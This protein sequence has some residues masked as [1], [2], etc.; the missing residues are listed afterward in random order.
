LQLD[1]IDESPL[2]V[3]QVAGLACFSGATDQPLRGAPLKEGLLWYLSA[4]KADVVD[5]SL[6]INGFSFTHSGEELSVSFSPFTLVRTC[7]LQSGSAHGDHLGNIKIFKLSLFTHGVTFFF[8]VQ[9]SIHREEE[10]DADNH[11]AEPA[12]KERAQWVIDISRCVSQVT[13][14]CFRPFTMSC[15]PIDK[16]VATHRRLMSGYLMHGEGDGMVTLLYCELH[17]HTRDQAKIALY[18]NEHCKVPVADIRLDHNSSC[19]ERIGVDCTC[20]C[21]EEHQ[22]CARSLM[23]RRLW[24]RAVSNVKVKLRNRAPSPTPEDLAHYR[25]AIKEYIAEVA[26]KLA[27]GQIAMD[28]LLRRCVSRKAAGLS[29]ANAAA[30][31]PSEGGHGS[32]LH[33]GIVTAS[34]NYS[35]PVRG[36]A[37]D[38]AHAAGTG[39]R[40]IGDVANA[41]FQ[42]IQDVHNTQSRLS[43]GDRAGGFPAANSIQEHGGEADDVANA[44]MVC[45]D[46][47][48]AG[49][50]GVPYV[51]V[52]CTSKATSVTSRG[53]IHQPKSMVDTGVP[54]E[55]AFGTGVARVLLVVGLGCNATAR[56]GNLDSALRIEQWCAS[57]E[58]QDVN[59]VVLS[60][61]VDSASAI[62]ELQ[63]S[64]YGLSK[65]CKPGDTCVIHI[66][67]FEELENTTEVG[68][69]VALLPAYVTLVCIADS[70]SGPQLLGLHENRL[71]STL[72]EKTRAILFVVSPELRSGAGVDQHGGMCASAMLRAADS[73]SLVDGPCS[74]TCGDFLA[75]MAEQLHDIAASSTAP[76]LHISLQ[77]HPDYSIADSVLWPIVAPPQSLSR[78]GQGGFCSV[79]AGMPEDGIGRWQ[80][81]STSSC[82]GARSGSCHEK[83]AIVPEVP[84]E[85]APSSES[86]ASSTGS[87]RYSRPSSGSLSGGSIVRS[88]GAASRR[89][90]SAMPTNIG[91]LSMFLIGGSIGEN[92]KVKKKHESPPVI[93]E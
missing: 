5:F 15:E 16:V 51:A 41:T 53:E 11:D 4:D 72:S 6:Y 14:S 18:E 73:L 76:R 59:L 84:E 27:D 37:N 32:D 64:A 77:A 46:G 85:K 25:D 49:A 31:L 34:A 40:Y 81:C 57:C 58:L 54:A 75:E 10:A 74:M 9:S 17:A 65:R 44:K 28:P 24:L 91:S 13:Q 33:S 50:G 70:R 83:L 61:V 43:D 47:P 78:R 21:I 1:D 19:C 89:K 23:E 62:A 29:I 26:A 45:N 8:G 12:E 68:N 66:V 56:Q 55:L 30:F 38:S 93:V 69:M 67:G 87:N 80:P 3:P 22:F 86:A 60:A 20:F 92:S 63:D 7:K 90:S 52:R 88:R 79:H 48:D 71:G 82:T 2:Q 39:V 42:A 35:L 36:T